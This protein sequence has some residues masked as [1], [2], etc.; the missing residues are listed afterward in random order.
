MIVDLDS[1]IFLADA[2]NNLVKICYIN[3]AERKVVAED[4][5]AYNLD[6]YKLVN[7]L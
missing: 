7:I 2:E 1:E 3:L 4:G 5:K 6:D